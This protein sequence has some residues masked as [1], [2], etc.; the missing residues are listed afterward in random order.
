MSIAHFPV[1]QAIAP[2]RG[3]R[4]LDCR[5]ALLRASGARWPVGTLVEVGAEALLAE[6]VGFEG[7]N[8]LLAPLAPVRGLEAGAL[9]VGVM[10]GRAGGG[11]GGGGDAPLGRAVDALGRPLD[12]RSPVA[13]SAPLPRLAASD[14]A[15]VALPLATGIRA[16]DALLTVGIGQRLTIA[17]PA[18]VGKTTLVTQLIKGAEVD[19]IVVG[20]IGERGR[21]IADFLSFIAKDGSAARTVVVAATSDEAP[22]LRL[23]AADQAHSVAEA[24]RA[25]GKSVLLVVDSLTRAAQAQREIGLALG[26]PA[27][28]GA[29][30]PSAFALIPRLVERAGGDRRSGG[31]IT[32]FY[33]VLAEG[34]DAD[35]PIVDAARAATDGHI[36]LSR[37]MAEQGVYPAIDLGASLSRTMPDVVAADHQADAM[38]ARRTWSIAEEYR[39]L[40]MLGGYRAG[41]DATVDAAI[42]RRDAYRAFIA[43]PRGTRVPF[44]QARRELGALVA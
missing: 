25:A 27:G 22:A 44:D 20:L 13:L 35:D 9:V 39:E 42:A 36:V 12:R 21:E 29:Y 19:A 26:E 1:P 24:L 18:G 14:R 30:P 43:Q 10:P 8:T 4:I 16:I 32:A 34:G 7:D 23:R 5:G 31:A 28:I 37:A 38:V 33:T 11:G 6:S 15:S 17:A 3:G 2:R 40:A 41:T